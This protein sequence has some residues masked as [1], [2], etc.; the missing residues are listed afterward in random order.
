MYIGMVYAM[1]S[2]GVLGFIVWAHHMFVVGLDVDTRAYFTAATMIIAVP[3]GIKIFSWLATLYGGVIRA[4]AP[5]LFTLG[6]LILF[7]I[8][9]VTGVVLANAGLDI[10]F[11]DTYY[12][13]A[14][15]HY[16]LSMGVVFAIFG[17]FYYWIEKGLGVCYNETLAAIHFW[18]F[19][20]GVNIT[21]FPMHFLGLAGM[22]R[23]IPDYPL[24]YAE[25]NLVASY[26]STI[27]LIATIFFFY[28]VYDMLDKSFIVTKRN[29]WRVYLTR[30][31]VVPAIIQDDSI[32]NIVEL[33]YVT[34]KSEPWQMNFQT[35]ASETMQKLVMLHHDVMFL[36][37][38]IVT[39]VFAC[40]L[41]TVVK[42]HSGNINKTRMAFQH[43]T[44][45]EQIW[46]IIPA[47]ILIVI[48]LPSFALLYSADELREPGQTIKI[49]GHQWYW[50]YQYYTPFGEM[51]TYDSYTSDLTDLKS[52]LRLLSTDA[53]I[54]ISGRH[55]TR[56]LI[57]AAD[58]LH[59]WALP[60]LAIKTDG[61][62]GRLNQLTIHSGADIGHYFGQ[63]SELCGVGH[64]FMS[65]EAWVTR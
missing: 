18:T 38:I 56:L 47:L 29:T 53:P 20:I 49:E 64:G 7:T 52:P 4:R 43:D 24:A 62:P 13:V 25:W 16:V 2:I 65:I 27:S 42:Y 63:C 55:N 8:G 14:H 17:G 5:M 58:V 45:L 59:S 33:P 61:C 35:P 11:H 23:R 54:V 37:V 46:T 60:A 32:F 6:F 10:A 26:G 3:T 30:L 57:T 48:A 1:L 51:V 34:Y 9:G 19:F 28:I 40:L 15:F 21:F 12:V 31:A 39:F 22:P 41:A 44:R 36:L 50:T